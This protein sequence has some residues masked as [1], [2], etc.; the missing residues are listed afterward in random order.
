LSINN[1]KLYVSRILDRSN[2]ISLN[3][4]KLVKLSTDEFIIKLFKDYDLKL[5]IKKQEKQIKKEDERTI[6]GRKMYSYESDDVYLAN[7]TLESI[8]EDIIK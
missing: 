7:L 8:K 2:Q 3:P 1:S 4:N 6:S 5:K